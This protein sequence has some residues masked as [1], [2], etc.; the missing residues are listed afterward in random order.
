MYIDII[1]TLDKTILRRVVWRFALVTSNGLGP[2]VVLDR[3]SEQ[4]RVNTRVRN[5]VLGKQYNRYEH[6]ARDVWPN[7]RIA[8]P[9]KVP[10]DVR[11]ELREKVNALITFDFN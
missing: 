11:K 1:R 3:Y 9:P 8:E 5:W 4:S 7:D 2:R 10:E 6:A